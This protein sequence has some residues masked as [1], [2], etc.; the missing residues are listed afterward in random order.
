MVFGPNLSRFPEALALIERNAGTRISDEHD[1][2]EILIQLANNSELRHEKGGQA[3]DFVLSSAGS[4]SRIYSH[5][6]G[7]LT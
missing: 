5:I 3:K 6:K 2:K 4:S 1:L 7:T